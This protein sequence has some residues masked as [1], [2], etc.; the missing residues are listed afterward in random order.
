MQAHSN[1]DQNVHPQKTLKI[2]SKLGDLATTALLQ[3]ENVSV[4]YSSRSGLFSKQTP[5][6]A[7]READVRLEASQTLGLVGESGCGKTSL[8]LALLALIKPAGGKIIFDR[9][10]LLALKRREMRELRRRMSLIFQDPA[11]SLPP[12]MK[13]GKIIA[14]PL[15]VH[16]ISDR[17]GRREQVSELL[18]KVGLD[19]NSSLSYPHQLSGGQRQ[20]VAIARA[21]ATSPDLVIADEPV[22]SLDITIQTQILDLFA[23]LR[24]E[25]GCAMI[26]ISHD[27]RVVKALTH[28]CQVMYLGVQ[29]EEGP[30]A[31]V[32]ASPLHP[33]TKLLIES[34][35]SLH[36]SQKKI[37]SGEDSALSFDQGLYQCPFLPRCS[38]SMPRCKE[39]LPEWIEDSGRGF[40]R[41]HPS[42]SHFE[43]RRVRCFNPL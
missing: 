18:S 33:Y 16:G 41:S 10:D 21:L 37:I 38:R 43:G 2:N 13:V 7:V 32:L 19:D 1:P 34:V 25:M 30:T 3:A 5:V 17:K 36:P 24:A 9:R 35:P 22:S 8:G 4:I 28:R 31:E 26:F 15:V 29:V 27:I 12:R 20:R 11:A 23:R 42:P 6:Y 40:D 14:E 39:A